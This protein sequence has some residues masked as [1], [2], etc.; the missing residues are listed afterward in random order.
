MRTPMFGLK[1]TKNNR[2]TFCR[3]WFLKHTAICV[4]KYVSTGDKDV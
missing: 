1:V 2:G 3:E 4:R